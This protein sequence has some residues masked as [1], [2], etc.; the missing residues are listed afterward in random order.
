MLS[1]KIIGMEAERDQ[2]LKNYTTSM[3]QIEDDAK[4]K[5]DDLHAAIQTKNN[6]SEILSAQ[7]NLKN[8]EITHLLEEISRLREV[9]REK[10]R[11]LQT[12]N[13]NE[14]N[15]LNKEISDYKKYIFELKRNL[16]ES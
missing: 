13:A 9:N 15:A 4:T 3:K 2:S 8:S 6:E 7:L 14:Q 16:S 11:K 1:Q 10:I 5:L 12:T